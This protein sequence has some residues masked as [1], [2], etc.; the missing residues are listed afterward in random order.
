MAAPPPIPP[1]LT[2]ANWDKNK[3]VFAKIAGKTGIGEA[4]TAVDT[5]YKN[6]D[7]SKFNAKAQLSRVMRESEINNAVKVATK[8]NSTTVEALRQKVTALKDL[9]N[10]TKAAFEKKKTIPSSSTKHVA[11][12]AAAAQDFLMALKSNSS[13]FDA[14]MK[15]FEDER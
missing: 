15:T 2:K 10:T 12:V 14:F 11:S 3:G 9:A 5:A 7:W 1:I 4:M 13:Y 6:V 8:E